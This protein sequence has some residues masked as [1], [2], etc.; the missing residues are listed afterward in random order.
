MLDR[1]DLEFNSDAVKLFEDEFLY[2][3]YPDYHFMRDKVKDEDVGWLYKSEYVE[4][5]FTVFL[6]TLYLLDDNRTCNKYN[7]KVKSRG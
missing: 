7:Y 2:R 6:N 1:Y 4:D 3:S 5:M